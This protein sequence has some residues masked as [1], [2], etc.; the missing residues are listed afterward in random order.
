MHQKTALI[1]GASQG[2]G[3]ELSKLFIKDGYNLILV[4][5]DEKRLNAIKADFLIEYDASVEII[6]A[7]LSH[8]DSAL[9][10]FE[11]LRLKNTIVSALVNNAG[12]GHFGK[13]AETDWDVYQNMLQLNISSLTRLTHLFLPDMLDM[14][15]G[16]IMNVASTAA[17]MPGPLMSIYYAS[18]AFVFSFSQALANELKDTNV[19]VNTL[20]PGPT[21]TGFQQRAKMDNSNVF[22]NPIMQVMDAETVARQGYRDLMRGK[23]LTI[24]GAFNKLLTQSVRISP[25]KTVMNITRWLMDKRE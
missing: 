3:Y 9:Q 25:R 11:T 23:T 20:C 17:F 16:F 7:D 1:T 18:K 10:I 4:A 21:E 8:P 15:Y 13:F 2:I 19:T 5:R 12:F 14:K 6:I 24:N 22:N